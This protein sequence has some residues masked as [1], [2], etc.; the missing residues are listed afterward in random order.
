MTALM[1][2]C[3]SLAMWPYPAD[4]RPKDPPAGISWGA[5][6]DGSLASAGAQCGTIS[7]PLD[8]RH[9]QSG[10]VTL[11]LSRV[12][13]TSPDAQYQ[14]VMLTN[15]GGPGGSGLGL[16]TLGGYVPDGA[17]STYDWIGFDPRGVGASIPSLSCDVAINGYNR[18]YYVPQTPALE[19]T[20]LNRSR[21]YA[22]K[23]GTAGGAL[24]DH[25]TTLDTVQDMESMRQALGV[26]QIN[27][28]GFSYGTYI[29][30]VYATLH[31][32]NVRRLVL[33]GVIDPRYVWYQS[34]LDQDP[35]F[36]RTIHAFF[37]W[38]GKRDSIYH[39]GVTGDAVSRNYYAEAEKLRQAPA[40][41][42]IGPD[43]L[44]DALL[45]AAY[46]VLFWADD[47]AAFAALVNGG[48]PAGIKEIYDIYR[49][50]GAGGDNENAMYLATECTDAEWPRDWTR[51][52]IDTLRVS[53]TAP[54]ETWGNTWFNAPCMTW[55]AKSGT[56][57]KVD[58]GKAPPALL[59][60]DTYDAATPFSG[61]LEVRRR[62]PRA[63]LVEGVGG[64]MHAGSLFGDSCIDGTVA[65]YLATGALPPRARG[66]QSDKKCA[67]LTAPEPSANSLAPQ[68]AGQAQQQIRLRLRGHR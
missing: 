59:I 25:V 41:G 53:L 29:G 3:L 33:D 57:V 22:R 13:H 63:A 51:W 11:A 4:A 20:W 54:F 31:P 65:T 9:P 67:P 45:D 14:G 16:A 48:D 27:Y 55:P 19:L 12:Q 28:Y 39:L 7:V 42:I 40:G 1:A 60:N 15:P 34:N 66:N 44:L 38:V 46:Y 36:E 5:C 17:G 21:D 52:K 61:A 58:G 8:Y 18:P 6:D 35:A 64:T 49:P 30:Q 10:R 68:S 23:C 56:P 32:E 37:D 50:Q 43:E 62:F 47:A 26:S 24:L 2:S